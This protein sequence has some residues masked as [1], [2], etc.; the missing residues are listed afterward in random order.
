VKNRPISSNLY[1]WFAVLGGGLAWAVQF[2]TNLYF[3]WARCVLPNHP[4]HSL[5]VPVHDWEIGL[6]LGAIAVG[7]GA[8]WASL[9]LF[10][11][12]RGLGSL[13][14]E[15]SHHGVQSPH[16]QGV[17]GQ[18]IEGIGAAPPGG[19]I[20]FLSM[21]ALTVNALALTIIIMTAIGAPLLPV[22]Q[23]S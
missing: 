22:C 16:H 7:A 9:Q 17:I 8:T 4:L 19:R 12:S 21:V 3:T 15:T 6:S 10:R 14:R 23:Q 20:A 11:R 5:G 13:V 1:V 18:E 2:V